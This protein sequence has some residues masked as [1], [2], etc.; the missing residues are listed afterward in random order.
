MGFTFKGLTSSALVARSD[1]NEKGNLT[2]IADVPAAVDARMSSDARGLDEKVLGAPH[3]EDGN[4]S[5]EELNRI[6]ATAEHGV[7]QVQAMT[8]VWNRR[9]LL[10]AYIM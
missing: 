3:S 2:D 4:Y 8:H 6:D 7:Q 10:F 9:D 1:A 5:D